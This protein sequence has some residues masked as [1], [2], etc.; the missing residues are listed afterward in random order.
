MQGWFNIKNAAQYMD[1]GERS[2]RE[3]VKLGYLP[4]SRPH[5]GPTLIKKEWM[6]EYL[7]GCIVNAD[8]NAQIDKIVREV[9]NG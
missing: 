9:V 3:L 8:I 6:D 5:V 4:C 2:V 7:E 1:V